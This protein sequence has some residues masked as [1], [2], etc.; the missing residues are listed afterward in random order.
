V[1]SHRYSAQSAFALGT[2]NF[3]E[4]YREE[5]ATQKTLGLLLVKVSMTVQKATEYVKAKRAKRQNAQN[6]I[7]WQRTLGAANK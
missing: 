3:G 5:H 4:S 1:L 7:V 2:T 6:A